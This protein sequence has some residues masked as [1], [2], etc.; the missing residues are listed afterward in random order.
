[1]HTTTTTASMN[2]S[3]LAIDLGKYKS[4]SCVYDQATDAVRSATFD[5]SRVSSSS[6]PDLS[7]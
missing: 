7:L 1:M 5:T 2:T 6:S 3:I 4:V